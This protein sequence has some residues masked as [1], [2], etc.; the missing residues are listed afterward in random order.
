M[1]AFVYHSEEKKKN[2]NGQV[3]IIKTYKWLLSVDLNKNGQLYI[4]F[5]R[6]S[7]RKNRFRINIDLNKWYNISI[8][9][10]PNEKKVSKVPK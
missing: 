2:W 3:K 4:A 9:Q 6:E 7:S 1:L 8:E 10:K 5:D